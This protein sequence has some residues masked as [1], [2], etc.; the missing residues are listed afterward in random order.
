M[1]YGESKFFILNSNF[2]EKRSG[3]DNAA[4]YRAMLFKRSLGI[5]PVIVTAT[6]NA[7]LNL[8]R[9]KLVETGLIDQDIKIINLYDDLQETQT[10]GI[11]R[12][13]EMWKSNGSW[14]RQ[15]I[16][17]SKNYRL[18]DRNSKLYVE[19][20]EEGRV[21][22]STLFIN[23]TRM[24]R[25]TF[26]TNGF[27]SKV[28]LYDPS[29]GK[30]YMEIYYRT[31][32]TTC[33]YKYFECKNDKS[34]LTAIHLIDR[35]GNI[36]HVFESEADL[37]THWIQSIIDPKEANFLIVDREAVYYQPLQKIR[38]D[39]VFKICMIHSKHYN[40]VLGKYNSEIYRIICEDLLKTEED[41]SKPDAVVVLT[42]RQ[43]EDMEQQLARR[44]ICL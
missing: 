30:I 19:P 39:N 44:S 33:I 35:I 2:G 20:D 25:E 26:D 9:R 40:K 18:F 27:L 1:N 41:S 43:R 24:R 10:E 15:A 37:L 12:Q 16:S 21:I 36:E 6:Y 28:E 8:Q 23:M 31:D 4:L 38:Q 29:N 17:N 11:M 32:G 34:V 22:F 42:N 13:N 3:I 14:R 5:F 7:R